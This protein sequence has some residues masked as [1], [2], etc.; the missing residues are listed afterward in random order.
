MPCDECNWNEICR[1]WR[2][3]HLR[4]SIVLDILTLGLSSSLRFVK[5]WCKSRSW[6]C[7]RLLYCSIIR[8][9]YRFFIFLFFC[10]S[11]KWHLGLSCESRDDHCHH[12]NAHGFNYFF[13]IPLT[14][15]RDCQPG[16]GTVFQIHKYLPYRTLG[17]ILAS[18]VLLSFTGLISISRNLTLSLLAVA[19]L[20]VGLFGG[21]I[22][23]IP[24]FNCV[25]MED[26]SVVE[27][28]FVSEN[29]TQKMTREAVGFIERY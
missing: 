19:V 24:T 9:Y 1:V 8:M 11:G 25:L 3:N 22:L 5:Y 7:Y 16:H 26:H 17:I 20:A 21:F 18:T 12:P 27:Q 13:G 4:L 6:M 2:L 29:L 14:N 23:I 15:L 28:P 10:C